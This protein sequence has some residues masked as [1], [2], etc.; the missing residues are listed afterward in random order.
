M[1]YAFAKEKY[2]RWMEIKG[3]A[4]TT[5]ERHGSCLRHFERFLL[6]KNGG[7]Q[8]LRLITREKMME[9]LHQLRGSGL[10]EE[11]QQGNLCVIAHLFSLLEKEGFLLVNPAKDLFRFKKTPHKL[12]KVLTKREMFKI[13][14]LPFEVYS[15][16]LRDRAI[17]EI[18]YSTGIR[19]SELC[20]LKESDVDFNR[21]ILFIRQG[22]GS[23]DRVVPLGERAL[24]AVSS[25][26]ASP[27][28]HTHTRKKNQ[29]LFLTRQANAMARGNARL[30]IKHKAR[31]AGVTKRIYPHLIRYTCATHLLTAGAP[32]S[33]IQGILGHAHVTTTEKYTQL[34]FRKIRSCY[35]K[36]HPQARWLCNSQKQSKNT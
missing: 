13:L 18:L 34:D 6:L 17:L 36:Y 2:F 28:R 4:K 5:Q 33:V 24:T 15:H 29:V 23:K 14:S 25:Y 9:Y 35:N 3:Y 8:D 27:Y 1:D 10:C 12:P 11:S 20:E 7:N 16:G 19:I 21:G 30:M 26:L 31:L 32:L 22:K